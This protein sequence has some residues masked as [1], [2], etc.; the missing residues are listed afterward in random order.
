[1]NTTP[2]EYK[3]FGIFQWQGTTKGMELHG[4]MKTVR[5]I[6]NDDIIVH[7]HTMDG[8]STW[9]VTPLSV[10]LLNEDWINCRMVRS[11]RSAN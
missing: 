10:P 1:M 4:T 7:D 11:H 2:E 6:Q 9:L 8:D 5:V 3:R